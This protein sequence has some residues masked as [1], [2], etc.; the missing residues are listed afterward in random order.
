M[1]RGVNRLP[2]CLRDLHILAERWEQAAWCRLVY[3]SKDTQ[4]SELYLKQTHDIWADME[5]T[6]KVLEEQ[7]KLV[8]DGKELDR[9][10]FMC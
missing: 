3:A 2:V 6:K 4:K 1:F 10:V 5:H 9:S 7:V 8:K